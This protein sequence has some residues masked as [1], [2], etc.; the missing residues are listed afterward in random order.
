MAK[1][2]E[3]LDAL[4][5]RVAY[6]H[7]HNEFFVQNPITVVTAAVDKILLLKPLRI[8]RDLKINGLCEL[9]WSFSGNSNNIKL[10]F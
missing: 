5:G 8:D 4:A 7:C 1:L 9:K 3:N 10:D 2:L 6:E